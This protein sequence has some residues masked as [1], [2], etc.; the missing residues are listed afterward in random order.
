MNQQCT[1]KINV[2]LLSYSRSSDYMIHNNIIFNIILVCFKMFKI[3]WGIACM[4]KTCTVNLNIKKV[5]KITACF[6]IE[7]TSIQLLHIAK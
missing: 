3:E 2:N 1:D 6:Q 7:I 5:Q 4:P